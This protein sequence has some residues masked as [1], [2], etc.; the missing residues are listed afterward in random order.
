VK[1]IKGALADVA[2][3]DTLDKDD[4]KVALQDVIELAMRRREFVKEYQDIKNK[5]ENYTEKNLEKKSFAE[6]TPKEKLLLK[7]K[8]EIDKLK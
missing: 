5:P 8:M 2:D 7:L 6:E 1:S 3:S 4:L